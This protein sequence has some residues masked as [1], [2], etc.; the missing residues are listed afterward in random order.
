MKKVLL[1]LV[2]FTGLPLCAAGRVTFMNKGPKSIE[3]DIRERREGAQVEQRSLSSGGSFDFRPKEGTK[4]A[5]Q[6]REKDGDM[7]T[8]TA[9]Y[10]FTVKDESM[11]GTITVE[12]TDPLLKDIFHRKEKLTYTSHGVKIS[13][14]IFKHT[15][16]KAKVAG[17]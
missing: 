5:F 10:N 4:Y 1:G 6:A 13:K 2:V 16:E 12:H 7:I 9:Y 11:P 14:P 15:W 8:E 3:I 17:K